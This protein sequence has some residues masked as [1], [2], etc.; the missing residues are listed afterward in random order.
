MQSRRLFTVRLALVCAFLLNCGMV[1][2]Q[3]N[4]TIRECPPTPNCVSSN[5]AADDEHHVLPF[6]IE[7]AS[8][9]AWDTIK[10]LLKS[11]ERFAVVE[12][13]DNYLHVEV[14]SL[15]FRFVDDVEFQLDEEN[16]LIHV[17]SAS[18]VG[19]WDFGVNR[20]RI[21]SLRKQLLKLGVIG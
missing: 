21:E 10:K 7:G 5:P 8:E 12:N 14:T 17:R 1:S 6:R 15:V 9:M 16:R 18:R 11:Q 19:Y 20:R 13:S 3:S 4:N 2:S